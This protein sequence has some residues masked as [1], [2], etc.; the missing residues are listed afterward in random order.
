MISTV[1]VL[2]NQWSRWDFYTWVRCQ[3]RHTMTRSPGRR[4]LTTGSGPVFC[5]YF[6]DRWISHA[7]LIVMF[8]SFLSSIRLST[9]LAACSLAHL[10][11]ILQVPLFSTEMIFAPVGVGSFCSWNMVSLQSSSRSEKLTIELEGIL[12]RK[13]ACAYEMFSSLF[14]LLC[15]LGLELDVC[16]L[17]DI[18]NWAW[19]GTF[20]L[21][22][23]IRVERFCC[24][25]NSFFKDFSVF[26]EK[27]S[28]NK[29]QRYE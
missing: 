17:S 7:N 20:P 10:I 4:C 12:D 29:I 26:Q 21:E 22:I 11:V 6:Q 9:S 27:T 1:C 13:A 16:W 18:F 14:C 23:T 2:T 24:N 5:P 3:W 15:A 19:D 25:K 28:L 8:S